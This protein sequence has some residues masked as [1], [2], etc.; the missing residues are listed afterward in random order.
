MQS[1][2]KKSLKTADGSTP[3]AISSLLAAL[4]PPDHGG[5]LAQVKKDRLRKQTVEDVAAC[6]I[7]LD[8]IGFKLKTP[9][10]VLTISEH[11][12]KEAQLRLTPKFVEYQDLSRQSVRG[13]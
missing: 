10:Q 9:A 4:K 12:L 6:R 2:A 8:S 1:Q 11:A 13:D 7:F 3:T 5:K